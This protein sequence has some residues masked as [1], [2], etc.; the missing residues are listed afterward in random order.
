MQDNT[1]I[2][3]AIPRITDHFHALN[4]VGW[5]GSAYLLTT[6]AFQLLFGKFYTFFSIKLVYLF[7]IF[8][9]E[10][11]SAL[12]GAAPTSTAL[13]IGRAIA[14]I[15]SAGIFCGA[16]II[17]A[18][19]VPLKSRP[20]F[21]GI[22]GAMYG[23]ASVAGPL[24]GGA[25]TDYLSWRWCFYINLPIGA[26]AFLV[27][28]V[29]FTSP[30]RKAEAKI[31]WKARIQ[32]FDIYGTALFLP[33]IICLL[34][35]LQWGGS[36]YAWGDGRIIALLVLFVVLIAGF[37]A[38]Q[39]WRGDNATVPIRIISQRNIAG[40]VVF[41]FCLGGSFFIMIYW[42]P[43]WF[44]AI[45][46][47]TAEK[48]GIDSIPLVIS[49][50][51]CNIISGVG[52][53]KLGYYTPFFYLSTILMAIG[54]GL[55]TTWT[56]STGHSKWIGYQV[57][58]GFGVGFG[59][60]QPLI[61]AQTVLP[62]HDVPVGTAIMV[63]FQSLGG[64]LFLSV[65][66]NIFTNELLKGIVANVPGV[67]PQLVITSGAT[68]LRQDIPAR[69]LEAV[70]VAYNHALTQTWYVSVAMACL[71]VFGAAVI[72]WKSVKGKKIE[73]VAA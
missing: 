66:Q 18:Y 43:V 15:G 42:V 36:M 51:I 14:G 5:Y 62:M 53:T 6:C 21:T 8:I 57:V 34:L 17:V 32:Q 1:I 35:A 4:D 52:T 40:S 31:S 10:V 19:S 22:I 23:I 60:Q 70:Y 3:T 65:G 24:M 20:A 11:G 64:A 2:A 49:L 63:F 44:Q 68:S 45:K 9:F 48:S 56:V 46:G 55:M 25:F 47:T 28:V 54:A 39:F 69:F 33:A 30:I 50:V 67:D 37:I 71:S 7:S 73:T 41:T 27:I 59:M 16:L 26:V 29:F 72:Q 58:F 61:C 12:C 38:I 13:I